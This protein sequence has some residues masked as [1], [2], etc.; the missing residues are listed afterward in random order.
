MGRK[1]LKSPLHFEKGARLTKVSF[2]SEGGSTIL[3]TLTTITKLL[4]DKWDAYNL[5]KLV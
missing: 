5:D 4:F 3:C 1:Y 2:E